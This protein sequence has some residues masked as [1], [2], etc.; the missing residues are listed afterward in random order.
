M[1]K[2]KKVIEQEELLWLKEEIDSCKSEIDVREI[3]H[4]LN[5]AYIKFPEYFTPR[6]KK[7]IYFYIKFKLCKYLKY[8][9]VFVDKD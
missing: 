7:L 4:S 5:D 6:I 3:Q 8:Q 2:A 1:S 9:S